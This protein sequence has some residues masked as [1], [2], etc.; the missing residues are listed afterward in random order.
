[1]LGFF[2]SL[3][4]KDNGECITITAE[5]IERWYESIQEMSLLLTIWDLVKNEDAG[6]LGQII[7]WSNSDNVDIR[8]E[9]QRKGTECEILPIRG[10]DKYLNRL[11]KNKILSSCKAD[12]A[13]YLLDRWQRGDVI[14]PALYYVCSEINKNLKGIHPQIFPFI[15]NPVGTGKDFLLVPHTLF[16]AMWLMFMWEITGGEN[17]NKCPSCGNWWV[18]TR[19]NQKYCSE[20]CKQ[21]AY[22]KRKTKKE[23]NNE[24][25]Y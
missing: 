14:Q 2:V 6:K 20:N 19:T 22:Y 15:E 9:W 21:N 1:M 7:I 25:S 18:Q 17:I 11:C 4:S 13:P 12:I 23:L 16:D 5:S 10:K 24:G 3:Y 8:L